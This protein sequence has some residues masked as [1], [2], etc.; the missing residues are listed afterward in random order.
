MTDPRT[1][2]SD[3]TRKAWLEEV[4]Q[5]AP[6]GG[7]VRFVETLP[8]GKALTVDRYQL[9]N[10][11]NLLL[12]ED[13]EA[14]VVAYHTWFSVGSRH[15]QVGK[16][17]LSHLFEHLM[18]NES[19]N[20]PA[21][22]FD[23]KM[24]EAGAEVNASTWLDWTQYSTALPKSQ[25]LT[26]IPLEAERMA[27]LVLKPPQLDS[28]KEVVANERRYRVEDDVDGAINELL[29]AT[30]FTEHAYRWPTIGWMKDIENFT[31]E[32]CLGF[33]RTYY[34]PNNATVVV[35]GDVNPKEVLAA[36]SQHYGSMPRSSVPLE[37]VRPE[38][39]QTEERRLVIEKPTQTEK[40]VIGYKSP[41]FGDFD[42][43]ALSLLGEVLAGGRASRLYRRLV[44]ELELASEVRISVGPFRDPSLLEIY[45]SAREGHTAEE[46]LTVIEEELA[47]VKEEPVAQEEMDRALAR[48]ELALLAS[49]ETADGKAST[50]GFYETVLGQP[51]A[52]FDRL[53]LEQRVAQSDLRRVARRYFVDT[54]RTVLF[55]RAK[56]EEPDDVGD[57]DDSD[58]EAA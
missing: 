4:N 16:T 49:L 33:Y 2:S 45:A 47:R 13:H 40:L 19:E 7:R 44:R 51:A 12:V 8:F 18:F 1:S 42:Y 23:R 54:Q 9:A 28:E 56:E 50:L 24:E 22:E 21:G 26:A 48:N 35:A 30:A 15:E 43:P 6:E 34:A 5:N 46:L 57:S 58:A 32:D 11:L 37:D 3:V 41:A 38:P 52:A 29:W 39:P 17:G 20:L 10:G 31:V 53:T 55:V 36:I 27:R 25:L 14:P